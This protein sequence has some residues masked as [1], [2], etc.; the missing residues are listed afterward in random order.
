MYTEFQEGEKYGKD[1]DEAVTADSFQDAGY[2]LAENDLIVDID[3]ISKQTIEKILQAFDIGTQIVWTDR[4]AHL[5]FRKPDSFK[6]AKKVTPLGFEVEYKHKKNTKAVTIKRNGEMRPIENAGVREELPDCM[7][8]RKQLEDIS[9]LDEGDGRNNALFNHRMKIQGLDDWGGMLRFIN[10]HIFAEP[11]PDEEFDTIVRDDIKIDARKDDEPEI[12]DFVMKKYKVV[13][14]IGHLYFWDK[15]EYISDDDK[16]KRIVFDEVGPKKTRYVDEILKQMEYRSR[17]IDEKQVFDIK[18]NNGILREGYFVPIDSQD[19]TPYH[20]DVEYDPDAEPI[21]EVEDYIGMLTNHDPDFRKLLF[22]IL[23][24]PLIVNKEFKRL[25]AKFFIFVGDGGN[26]KGTLLAIIRKILNQKNCSGLSVAH[27]SDERYL[28]SMIGKLANLGDD[29][30]DQAID[31][32]QMKQLKN[33]STCDFISTREL[34]KTPRDVEVTAS[35]IFTS[36]HVLKSFEKGTSYQR[37]VMWLPMYSK[38]NNKDSKFI[39]KLT[40]DAALKYWMKL[41]VEG[42]ERLYKQEEFTQC[43]LVNKFNEEYHE[44]NNT[45]LQFLEFTSAEWF[46]D[47]KTPKAYQGYYDWAED[48]GLNIQGRKLFVNTV[49]ETHGLRIGQKKVDGENQRVFKLN[50]R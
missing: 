43:E 4:G 50:E 22:E 15:G 12:A 23:A 7:F 14:Y 25:L 39:T 41:I 6:R 9:E 30:Q 44:D 16:L 36:N 47:K 46:L 8:T 21:Q 45:V 2:I 38:P 17:I 37:R 5:Y 33:I 28:S 32:D 29:I 20:V 48:N 11:L 24:H 34:Y 3:N 10:N 31:N 1:G 18:L 27:M 26:G 19:F 35:L 40:T 42:Y 49:L 13:S